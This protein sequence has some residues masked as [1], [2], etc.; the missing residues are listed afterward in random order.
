MI[1]ALYAAAPLAEGSLLCLEADLI[2]R[3]C[4]IWVH[5]G[6]LQICLHLFLLH[7]IHA[8]NLITGGL[9][10]CSASFISI[11]GASVPGNAC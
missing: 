4:G 8:N 7:A 10:K 9:I 1:A 2:E 6:F 5:A 3:A 11:C